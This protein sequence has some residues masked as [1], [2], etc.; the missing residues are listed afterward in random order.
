VNLNKLK[1]S[2]ILLQLIA[3][4]DKELATINV[5]T[6]KLKEELSACKIRLD[7]AESILTILDKK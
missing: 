4:L 7:K 2:S 5:E 6:N 3:K 1:S